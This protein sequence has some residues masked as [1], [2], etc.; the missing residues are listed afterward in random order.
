MFTQQT[1]LF[2]NPA[3]RAYFFSC[4][5]AMFGNGLTYIIMIWVLMQFNGSVG[6]TAMLMTCFWLPNVLLSPYFGVLADRSNRKNMLLI[7]NGS[8]ALCLFIFAWYSQYYLSATSVYCIAVVVGCVLASYTP[9]AMT[10]IREIMPEDQ[11]MYANSMIDIAY[12]MGAVMGMG[13]AGLILAV[14]SIP[15]CFAINGFCYLLATLLIK[16]IVYQNKNTREQKSERFLTQLFQGWTYLSKRVPLIM[17]YLV[18]AL[19]FVCYMTAPVL[20]GPFATSVLHA[21]VMQFGL[22]E[23]MLSVGII[24]G[25]FA[26]PWFA[27]RYSIQSVILFLTGIGIAAFY[28]FSHTTDIYWAYAFHFLIGLSFSVWALLITLA[29]EMTDIKVQGRVQSLFN[30]FSGLLILGFYYIIGHWND[31]PI[32]SLYRGELILLS[33]SGVIMLFILL[34]AP[35]LNTTFAKSN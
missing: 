25:G 24:M 35:D 7:A 15:V 28:L 16:G 30:S 6:S 29:Q 4:M 5:L 31:L 3:F 33:L 11:M 27:K 9:A 21:D 12:E 34:K 19:F 20:L 2:K 14:A 8:R 22:L 1:E 17:L 13:G 32:I 18:Q 26:C 10:F 23:A